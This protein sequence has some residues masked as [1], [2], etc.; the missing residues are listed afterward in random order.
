M[1]AYAHYDCLAA[2]YDALRAVMSGFAA[3][4]L[5]RHLTMTPSP[6]G[7]GFLFCLL[8]WEKGDRNGG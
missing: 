1:S 3:L 4:S 6:T 5:I 2:N 7:E 8:L